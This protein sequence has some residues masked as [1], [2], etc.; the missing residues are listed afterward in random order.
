MEDLRTN[1][2]SLAHV[3]DKEAKLW[4]RLL[5]A[6]GGEDDWSGVAWFAVAT[7]YELVLGGSVL[8]QGREGPRGMNVT[9]PFMSTIC[10]RR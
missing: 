5:C 1:R 9:I 6:E 8:S 3:Q 10:E 2:H 7:H 4:K